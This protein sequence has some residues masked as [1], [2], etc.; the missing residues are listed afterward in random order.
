MGV[1]ALLI[2][3]LSLSWITPNRKA[4]DAA[5][6]AGSMMVDGILTVDWLGAR[7]SIG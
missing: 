1:A 5:N 7:W 3:D 6:L 4:L 2:L